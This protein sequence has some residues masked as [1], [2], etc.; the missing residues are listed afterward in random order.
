MIKF[1]DMKPLENI[2]IREGSYD[3]RSHTQRRRN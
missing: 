1:T 2:I 3:V